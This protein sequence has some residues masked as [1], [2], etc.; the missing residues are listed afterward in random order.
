MDEG[1][2]GQT[3][4]LRG[5]GERLALR[6]SPLSTHRRLDANP[7]RSFMF[8]A[9]PRSWEVCCL[10]DVFNTEFI[11]RRSS[12][13][14]VRQTTHFELDAVADPKFRSMRWPLGCGSLGG[15]P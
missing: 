6:A 9:P 8:Y 11:E 12:S 5:A 4:S 2:R 1:H 14:E 3:S 10:A 13:G 7:P 15:C